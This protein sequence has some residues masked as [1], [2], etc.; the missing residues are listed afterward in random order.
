MPNPLLP[1]KTYPVNFFG[2]KVSSWSRCSAGHAIEL[3]N[4]KSPSMVGQ[5][6]GMVEVREVEAK[7]AECDVGMVTIAKHDKTL[8]VQGTKMVSILTLTGSAVGTNTEEDR[9]GHLM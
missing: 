5:N 4:V 6:H 1:R 7:I 2:L 8:Q 3:S 9:G